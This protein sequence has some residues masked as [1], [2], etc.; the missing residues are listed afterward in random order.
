[1]GSANSL[2]I[3]LLLA[4]VLLVFGIVTIFIII[5]IARRPKAKSMDPKKQ[6]GLKSKGPNAW[7]EA[8]KRISEGD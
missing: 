8:G 6:V 4:V 3:L 2:L 1:M 7:E 5:S